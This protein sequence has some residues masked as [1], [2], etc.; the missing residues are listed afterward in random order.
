MNLGT[1]M[2]GEKILSTVEL[3]INSLPN[4]NTGCSPVLFELWA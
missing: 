4:K 1:L 2:I 3:A